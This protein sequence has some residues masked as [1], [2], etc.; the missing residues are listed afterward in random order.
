MKTIEELEKQ[1][2]A[3]SEQIKALKD[4][5]KFEVGK[6]Y[7]NK[8]DDEYED[9][10][11]NLNEIGSDGL[12]YGYGFVSGV[13]KNNRRV[14]KKRL[15][16]AT[17][18]EVKAA[19]VKEAEKRYKKGQVVKCAQDGT[20]WTID[21]RFDGTGFTH[22]SDRTSLTDGSGAYQ[23]YNGQWATIIKNDVIKVGSYEVKFHP[24][25]DVNTTIDGNIFTKQFW[26][27]AKLISEHSKA[28]IM[29]GCSKQFDV[30]LETINAILDKL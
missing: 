9:C 18:E 12:A 27:S 16:P 2:A 5:P 19:L 7:G 14:C 4:K 15:T 29:V 28:K 24:D 20:V 22:T 13:W 3:I 1:V 17:P 11:I 10:L 21:A 26:Q 8:E 30:S 25:K 6:W 23:F